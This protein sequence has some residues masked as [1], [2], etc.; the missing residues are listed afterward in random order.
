MEIGDAVSHEMESRGSL[1]KYY[2]LVVI[3][4]IVMML[5]CE[6]KKTK[7]VETSII[8]VDNDTFI[9]DSN[10]SSSTEKPIDS[11][12]QN[13][14]KHT[15]IYSDYGENRIQ[16]VSYLDGVKDGYSKEYHKD[17]VFPIDV[18]YYEKN[19]L[20]WFAFTWDLY[21]Y[22]VPVKGFFIDTPHPIKIEIPYNNGN[23]MYSGKVAN[24]VDG[25]YKMLGKHY[26]YYITGE[27]KVVVDY[28]IDSIFEFNKSGIIIN[29]TTLDNWYKEKVGLW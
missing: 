28:S 26:S 4:L 9:I 13:I 2:L 7:N 24:V 6:N 20:L 19:K 10:F 11:D 23:L 16:E 18:Q 21:F 15:I 22:S 8:E 1:G 29:S 17:S 5:S 14:P 3:T 12:S 25:T 27:L